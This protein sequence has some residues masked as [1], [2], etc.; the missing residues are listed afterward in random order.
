M[1]II[2]KKILEDREKPSGQR[3]ADEDK[4]DGGFQR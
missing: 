2:K 1:W 3:K 4:E